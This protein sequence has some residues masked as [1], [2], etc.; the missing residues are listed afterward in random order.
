MSK[1]NTNYSVSILT[2][3]KKKTVQWMITEQGLGHTNKRTHTHASDFNLKH[4]IVVLS[5][6]TEWKISLRER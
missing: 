1:K 2:D 4:Q 5:V 6:R 3:E